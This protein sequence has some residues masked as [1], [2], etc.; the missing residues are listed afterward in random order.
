VCG[1]L[2]YTSECP[3]G[4]GD[5]P[6]DQETYD[7]EPPDPPVVGKATAA[8][9]GKVSVSV[10]AE[11]RSGVEV[12]NEEE[13]V[14]ARATGTGKAQTVLFV[15]ESGLHTYTARATDAAG[16]VSDLGNPTSV[17]V[18]A[19][20]PRV[21]QL[22][23]TPARPDFGGSIVAFDTEP[24]AAYD[25]LV[26]G[27]AKH[28]KGKSAGSERLELWLPNG[29]YKVTLVVRDPVGNT[30]RITK[31]LAVSVAR[32]ALTVQR[33]TA[34]NVTPVVF[35]ITASPRSTGTMTLGGQKP[36]TFTI[37]DD[38]QAEVTLPLTDGSYPAA[39]VALAD[40]AGRTATATTEAFNLDTTAP[41]LNVTADSD[42]AKNGLLGLTISAERGARVTLTGVLG[43]NRLDETFT[44]TSAP[45]SIN[46]D[47]AAGRHTIIA[48]ATD[49]AGN[50]ARR[51]LTVNVADPLTGAELAIALAFLAV[52]LGGLALAG[53][54]LWRNRASITAWRER[55]RQEALAAAQRRAAAEAAAAHQ[56]T[57]VRYEADLRAFTQ[58]ERAWSQRR[59]RLVELLQAAEHETGAVSS[60]VVAV[61]LRRDEQ[62]L[63]AVS[64]VLLERRTRQGEARIV[65]AGEGTVAVTS[66]RVVFDGIKHREWAFN[67]L[68]DVQHMG[69]DATLMNVANRQTLSGVG[70]SDDAERTRLMID[71]AI[72]D[73]HGGRP[74]VVERVRQR[75]VEHDRIR[76]VPPQQ[77]VPPAAPSAG[78]VPMPRPDDTTVASRPR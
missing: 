71:L 35:S 45:Q 19:D 18:D 62:L 20:A 61:K 11:R 53:W 54:L 70:Y 50:Q 51:T 42:K 8:A 12:L 44:A 29:R 43:E 36:V 73:S 74:Q 63:T 64:G 48:V 28:I 13:N 72:A 40:F 10:T 66:Q 4:G 57:V 16:N 7:F 65:V 39:T 67:K 6:A 59:A 77:P 22:V 9:G 56:R 75:I 2:G 58:A 76:P 46:R 23:I 25:L 3:T 1:D 55:R 49:A 37:G 27:R 38:G 52:V 47:A 69:E 32:P 5:L 31:R 78:P 14:V 21:K 26:A 30:T 41:T 17:T 34:D 68:Q 60:H 33:T 15:A 24:G